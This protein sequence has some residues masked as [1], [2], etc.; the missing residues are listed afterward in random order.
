[1]ASFE[2][3]CKHLS[4]GGY[5]LQH[6]NRK[7]MTQKLLSK[8]AIIGLLV[9]VLA[10][11]F[12]AADTSLQIFK[13][14]P[15]PILIETGS[16]KGDGIQK[17]LDAGFQKVYSIE[18]STY[19]YKHCKKRFASN[20]KVEVLLGDSSIVLDELLQTIDQPVTFWLDGH[21]SD[22]KN[23]AQG[24]KKCPILSEL[25]IISKHHLKTHTILIDDIRLFGT[26]HFDFISLD[27]VIENVLSIN[28]KYE[29]KFEEGCQ[30]E[31]VLVAY[32][33]NKPIRKNKK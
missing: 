27:T 21:W 6:S 12:L 28:P 5:F 26:S 14:Y 24:E 16:F 15:N 2:K 18:L 23:A 17:A 9:I 22:V 19:Y 8:F 4:L 29:I 32:V 25:E 20:E 33:I 31:D 13:K 1:M 30:P 7:I 11:D 3:E 10:S